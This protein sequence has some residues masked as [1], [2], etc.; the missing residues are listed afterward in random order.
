MKRILKLALLQPA[1]PIIVND[2]LYSSDQSDYLHIKLA[3]PFL[4]SCHLY[5]I[6]HFI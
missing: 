1:I 4:F 5:H 6:C 2:V 3:T